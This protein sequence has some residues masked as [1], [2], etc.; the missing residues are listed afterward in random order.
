MGG[1]FRRLRERSVGSDRSCPC[2]SELA[3]KLIVAPIL[4]WTVQYVRESMKPGRIASSGFFSIPDDTIVDVVA[5]V[6]FG[7][8]P[9]G[10]AAGDPP[11]RPRSRRSVEKIVGRHSAR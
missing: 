11:R 3:I 8:E 9:A 6:G 7:R 10:V 5:A 2:G 4:E 1:A